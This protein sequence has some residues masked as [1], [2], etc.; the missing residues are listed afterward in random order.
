MKICNASD[1]HFSSSFVWSLF[2]RL[3]RTK[4]LK[5][6]ETNEM[7]GKTM[8]ETRE[9]KKNEMK[10]FWKWRKRYT[11]ILQ[12]QF[13][14]IFVE[15]NRKWK[16]KRIIQCTHSI[17]VRTISKVIEQKNRKNNAKMYEIKEAK[18]NENFVVK[19]SI[20][21]HAVST[22]VE[23]LSFYRRDNSTAERESM[24]KNERPACTSH[25]SNVRRKS[26]KG[27]PQMKSMKIVK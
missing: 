17:W 25:R 22:W 10:L 6:I 11:C 27:A 14:G 12:L 13:A 23:R 15:P 1:A 3:G 5:T 7:K 9:E 16:R 20:A 21:I 4:E 18:K 26:T 2:P 8:K 19:R 24:R